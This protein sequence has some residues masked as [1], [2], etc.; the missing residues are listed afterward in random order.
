[1]NTIQTTP[2]G[3]II[4]HQPLFNT[5]TVEKH[6]SDTDGVPVKYVCTTQM[7]GKYPVDIYYRSTPHPEFGNKYFGL[8]SLFSG[9]I[10]VSDADSVQDLK[11][12]TVV[13]NQGHHHYSRHT[14]DSNPVGI[15]GGRSYT[16]TIGD[17]TVVTFTVVNGELM[18]ATK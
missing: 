16:R 5:T 7:L 6:Y 2:E 4:V 18:E 11:F 8:N 10:M 12:D 15:D 13:D 3:K 14:H 9:Q 1:M 17:V